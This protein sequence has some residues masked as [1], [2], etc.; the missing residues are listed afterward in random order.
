[1]PFYNVLNKTTKKTTVREMTIAEMVK[2][3]KD[4]PNL[5]VVPGATPMMEARLGSKMMKPSEGFKDV[6]R[7]IK[8]RNPGTTIDPDRY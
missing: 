6:L 5:D 3:L 4:D 2:M 7:D 1:M 8:R